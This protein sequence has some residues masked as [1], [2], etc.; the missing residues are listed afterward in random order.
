MRIDQAYDQWSGQYDADRNRTR[1]MEASA[2]REMLGGRPIRSVLEIGCGTGKNTAWLATRCSSLTAVD[3]SAGMLEVARKKVTARHVHFLQAD[4]LQ[5]WDFCD[6]QYDLVTFSL[7]LEHVQDPGSV[8]AK[9]AAVLQPGG[10][11]Y[12][13]ELHP[14]KQ[15]GGTQARF[16]TAE[17]TRLVTCFVHHVSDFTVPAKAVGLHIEDVREFF[18]EDAPASPPRLLVLMLRK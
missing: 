6:G 17:G 14:Y 7:V 9:A 11:V 1:D 18:D 13:G 12:I 3:F 4:V 8:L 10:L 15:Y 16:E 2:L 5:P